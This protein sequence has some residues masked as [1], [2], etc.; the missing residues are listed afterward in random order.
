MNRTLKTPRLAPLALIISLSILPLACGG[1]GGSSGGVIPNPTTRVIFDGAAPGANPSLSMA[2]DNP[3]GMTFK[4]DIMVSGI[5]DLFGAAFRVT[6]DSSSAT[7][8]GSSSANSVLNG[9]GA[10]TQI[11]AVLA[12]GKTNELIVTATRFQGG[13]GTYV[14]SVDASNPSLLISLNFTAVGTSNGNAFNFGPATQREVEVCTNSTETC[15]MVD[16][17]T[18]SWT[19]GNMTTSQ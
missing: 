2:D 12:P 10:S 6:F 15:S 8:T 18:L 9:G 1:G 14:P 16:D 4:V 19:G 17:G 13:T 11:T 5:G 3:T 7:F